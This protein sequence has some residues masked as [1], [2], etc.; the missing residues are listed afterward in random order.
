MIELHIAEL[1]G[2]RSGRRAS[3][4][5]LLGRGKSLGV[6]IVIDAL[7]LDR[8]LLALSVWNGS[9]SNGVSSKF[10]EFKIFK[11][12]LNRAFA[13]GRDYR[14]FSAVGRSRDRH[15][16][17]VGRNLERLKRDRVS[18]CEHDENIARRDGG[19]AG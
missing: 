16:L 10:V 11:I 15:S 2:Y 14:V 9:V 18:V 19:V 5:Y 17:A 12:D 13:V 1:G 6:F 3:E 4:A 8:H 7:Q